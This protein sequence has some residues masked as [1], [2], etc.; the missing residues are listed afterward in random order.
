MGKHRFFVG[1]TFLLLTIN[2]KNVLAE[3]SNKD[4]IWQAVHNN[5]HRTVEEIKRDKYRNPDQVLRF[6]EIN[7]TSSVGEVA[8]GGGW[9]TH[10]LAPLLKDKGRYVGLQHN[11]AYYGKW[12]DWAKKLSAYPEKI[13]NEQ[14]LYGNNAIG[15]WL[16]AV[17]GLPVDEAS[18]DFVFITR[19]MHNWQNQGRLDNGLKQS[20]KILKNGGVLAIVQH[21][22]AESSTKNREVSSK[23]GRWKQSDL[24]SVVESFGFKLVASSEINA[25]LKDTK[26]YEKGVWTLPPSLALKEKDKEIYTKIGESD[27]MTLKFVKI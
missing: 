18:L 10:I 9:Y 23:R 6:F 22:E 16:P 13:K 25:N 15:T 11:P 5:S 14:N 17:E 24:I 8:P 2:A 7:E 27:R 1:V 19:T 3:S 12:P 4:A 21:R 20:W 26:D